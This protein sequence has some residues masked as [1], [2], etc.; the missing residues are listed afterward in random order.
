MT[1]AHD[2]R[3]DPLGAADGT[4]RW[5]PTI[6]VW[7]QGRR[8]A[9]PTADGQWVVGTPGSHVWFAQSP[10][11]ALSLLPLLERPMSEV[12]AELE[13]T[14]LAQH[15]L[16]FERVVGFALD[17]GGRWAALAITWLEDGF[18]VAGQTDALRRVITYHKK[19]VAQRPR[20]SA[21]RL[22]A[23]HD[24]RNQPHP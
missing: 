21:A 12:A 13:V 17:G 2:W 4:V 15:G 18:P 24:R 9:G 1:D 10:H 16:A 19:N 11:G 22:L 6:P 5:R 14:S 23:A 8:W 3:S 7:A 20:Q